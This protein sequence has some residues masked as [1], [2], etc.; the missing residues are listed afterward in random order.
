MDTKE[1]R[2]LLEK[3]TPGAWAYELN[4]PKESYWRPLLDFYRP[5]ETG[6]ERAVTGWPEGRLCIAE[7]DAA[8]IVAAVNNLPAL[9]DRIEALEEAVTVTTDALE[10]AFCHDETSADA[11]LQEIKEGRW[12]GV[13]AHIE[14]NRQL[15]EAPNA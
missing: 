1:L 6:N 8:L 5:L 9:L 3:A 15:L 7:P 10:K 2:E 14:L 12:N 11:L 13:R 4:G